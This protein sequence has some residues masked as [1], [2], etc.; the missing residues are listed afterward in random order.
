MPKHTGH[1]FASA[2]VGQPIP[3][4]EAFDADDQL[5]PVGRNG[6]EKW[7]WA[8]RHVS[9][10]QHLPIPVEETEVHG[11]GM[12]VDATITLVLFGVASPEISSS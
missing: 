5:G 12:Q 8:R 7:L 10:H 11:A 3:G 6:L 1:A 4:Q 2:E 9:V